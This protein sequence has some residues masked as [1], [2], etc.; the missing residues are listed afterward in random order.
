MSCPTTFPRSTAPAI[1]LHLLGAVPL[2]PQFARLEV[3][4]GELWEFVH[5]L[6]E[7]RKVEPRDDFIS[8]LIAA[9]TQEALLTDDEVVWSLVNLLFAGQDTTRYQLASAVRVLA[10]VPGLWDQIAAS[11]ER[12]PDALDEAMRL[13]PVSQFVVRRAPLPAVAEGFVFPAGRRLILNLLAASRD[14]DAFSEPERFDPDRTATYRLPF[15]WGLHYCLG[16]A[17]AR[18]EMCE[19]IEVM[20]HELTVPH[21]GAAREASAAGMLGGP[22]SLTMAFDRRLTR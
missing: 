7:R 14:P 2:A 16:Q 8:A 18:T 21:V 9:Q 22:E 15:G 13:R 12:V 3:A 4:L 11:P 1:D 5:S 20:T 19:A 17:L 6:V 10:Q